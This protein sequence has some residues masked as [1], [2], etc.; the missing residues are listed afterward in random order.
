METSGCN[1]VISI[2]SSYNCTKS[3]N[4]IIKNCFNNFMRTF[5]KLNVFEICS[6]YCPLECDSSS[7]QV[8]INTER[9]PTTG[10]ISITTNINSFSN[11]YLNFYKTYEDLQK[12]FFRIIIYYSDLKYIYIKQEPK[13]LIADLVSNIGGTFG[14][15]LGI[16]FLSLIE[17]VEIIIETLSVI[18]NFRNN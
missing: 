1:C 18:T 10:N 17:F 16:S 5:Q 11:K 13:T 14:L 3:D 4:K 12:R 7:F 15:F 6:K 9:L 2:D 8:Y